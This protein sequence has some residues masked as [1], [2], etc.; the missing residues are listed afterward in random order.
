MT[1]GLVGNIEGPAIGIIW[2]N[3]RREWFRL[4]QVC[5]DP[6]VKKVGD[7]DTAWSETADHLRSDHPGITGWVDRLSGP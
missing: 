6:H 1:L 7:E 2:R 4:C 3:S 5:V